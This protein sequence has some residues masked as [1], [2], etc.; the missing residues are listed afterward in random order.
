MP[1]ASGS[2]AKIRCANP[3]GRLEVPRVDVARHAYFRGGKHSC[4]EVVA[5]VVRPVLVREVEREPAA[6]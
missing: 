2:T 3:D 5:V 4:V 6:I 1:S